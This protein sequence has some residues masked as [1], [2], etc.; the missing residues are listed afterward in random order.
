LRQAGIPGARLA[1]RIRR[2]EYMEYKTHEEYLNHIVEPC[3]WLQSKTRFDP[4]F[5]QQCR[6]LNYFV[7]VHEA[8]HAVL[9]EYLGYRVKAVTI[10]PHKFTEVESSEQRQD[11][12]HMMIIANA[13]Y[14][15]S[16]QVI[17]LRCAFDLANEDT[18]LMLQISYVEQWNSK[19]IIKIYRKCEGLVG[20]NWK[21]IEAVA[22]K[23]AEKKTLTGD[24][25]RKI[26]SGI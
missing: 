6:Y 21:Q 8:A 19:Q 15:A 4:S 24:E 16:V 2:Q 26:I 3:E 9:N 14:T 23:L 5:Y 7:A 11:H 1:A 17:N 20:Q 10:E 18:M 12:E 13:G 25:V 22:N